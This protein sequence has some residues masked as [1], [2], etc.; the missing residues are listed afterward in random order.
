MDQARVAPVI[1]GTQPHRTTSKGIRLSGEVRQELRRFLSEFNASVDSERPPYYRLDAYFD[2][3]RLWVLEINASF[4]D[5][6]GTA[7]NLARAS[8]I[9][10]DPTRLVFPKRFAT[11]DPIY[12]PELML[13]VEELAALGLDGRTICSSG[14]TVEPIYVYGRVGSKDQPQ[15]L[16]YDG[17][18]L[19]SKLNLGLF[20]RTWTGDRVKTPRH[21]VSRFDPWE[22]VPEDIVLKFANK[23]SPACQRARQS[24]V[25]G[26]PPGKA[27]FLKR[28]YRDEALLA[29]EYVRPMRE[30]NQNCQLVIMAIGDE[31]ITGYIQYHWN[32]VINDASTHG[33]LVLQ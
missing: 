30:D 21:Y 6:W 10:V 14:E 5:G 28:C 19:D 26:K 13:F 22:A 11:I 7:L 24:V 25:F 23:D 16:P 33:P 27:P 3:E 15:I 20:S 32:R 2:Q 31:P 1:Y 12:R 17:L 9:G 4:V 18:R 8:G 29:Q